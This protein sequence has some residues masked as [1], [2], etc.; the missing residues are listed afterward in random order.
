LQFLSNRI[1]PAGSYCVRKRY[2][3]REITGPE[4]PQIKALGGIE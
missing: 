2:S 4:I 3:F 1:I